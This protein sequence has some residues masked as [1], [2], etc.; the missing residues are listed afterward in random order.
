MN[1]HMKILKKNN[2]FEENG[3][4]DFEFN[5]DIDFENEIKSP[6]WIMYQKKL[7]R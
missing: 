3:E 5:Q 4:D 2:Y 7:K 6:G 1:C